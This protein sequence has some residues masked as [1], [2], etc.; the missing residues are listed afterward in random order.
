MRVNHHHITYKDKP[1]DSVDWIVEV[2]GVDHKMLTIL[3]RMKSTP[4]NYAHITN[5]LHAVAHEWE[6]MRKDLDTIQ[7]DFLEED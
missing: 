4:E 2:N 5:V 7:E 3:Q 6:R 1:M